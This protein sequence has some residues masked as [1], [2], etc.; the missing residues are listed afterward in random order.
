MRYRLLL[1]ASVLLLSACATPSPG[2]LVGA[3]DNTDFLTDS[4]TQLIVSTEEPVGNNFEVRTL[5]GASVRKIGSGRYRLVDIDDQGRRF[6]AWGYLDSQPGYFAGEVEGEKRPLPQ[7]GEW[8][9][10][11]IDSTGT[12]IAVTSNDRQ[13][14]RVLSFEDLRVVQEVSCL[15]SISCW[16]VAWD[17]VESDVL[18]FGART[19][20]GFER[21]DL[22]TGATAGV[23]R[24]A[25]PNIRF[26]PETVLYNA[27]RCGATG[28]TLSASD[29]GINL[30]TAD[31]VQLL[32][33]IEGRSR[34]QGIHHR[35]Q[36]I[37]RAAFIAECRY[38]VFD[39]DGSDWVVE[40]D[41]G[42][43]GRLAGRALYVLP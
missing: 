36:A 13:I 6:V 19:H 28:A 4:A 32:V 26:P 42:L 16:W 25:Y 14:I 33:T 3:M 31:R 34:F 24:D 29:T 1:V 5:R 27:N 35:F 39:F 40:M 8:S 7:S 2:T 37:N 9:G 38:V 41:T 20:G 17:S 22:E 18:W 43:I 12:R 10:A 23:P 30:Q 11:T 21:L 15:P